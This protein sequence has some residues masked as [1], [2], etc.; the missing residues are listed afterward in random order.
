MARKEPDEFLRQ[1]EDIVDRLDHMS[2]QLAEI[3][4]SN[5]DLLAAIT[6]NTAATNKILRSSER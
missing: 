5:K 6:K 1:V 4:K 2:V 3:H